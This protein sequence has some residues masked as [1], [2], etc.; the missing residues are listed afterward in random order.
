MDFT[1]PINLSKHF[2]NTWM[3]KW[4]WDMNYLRSALTETY[5]IDKVGNNKYEAYT[6]KGGKNRK[7]IFTIINDEIFIITGAER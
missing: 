1:K 7:I 3:R 4:N 6:K 2:R 5:K